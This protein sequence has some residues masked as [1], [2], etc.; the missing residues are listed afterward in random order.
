MVKLPQLE[1]RGRKGA[2]GY[3][4]VSENAK[5]IFSK[6][7]AESVGEGEEGGSVVI[8]T[9]GMLKKG[10]ALVSGPTNES[11]L[12]RKKHGF[13]DEKEESIS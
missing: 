12:E 2:G 3:I 7:S 4:A 1:G 5:K 9:Q 8:N 6:N 13:K 11:F 10:K